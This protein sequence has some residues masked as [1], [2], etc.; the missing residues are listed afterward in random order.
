[1]IDFPVI[2]NRFTWINLLG[3]C[4][5]RLDRS[6]LDEGLILKWKVAGQIVGERDV[7][8]YRPIWI[9]V[10]NLNCGTRLFK[11]FN[12]WFEHLVFEPLVDK[13]CSPSTV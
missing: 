4:M 6:L 13:V 5:S 9:H 7:S 11:V 8:D 10:N 1:M 2:G 12:T 3:S